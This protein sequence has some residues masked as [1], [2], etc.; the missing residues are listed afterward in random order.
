MSLSSIVGPHWRKPSPVVSE[1]LAMRDL[2]PDHLQ[3]ISLQAVNGWDVRWQLM[4][5]RVL[6][7]VNTLVR[8]GV[9]PITL[10]D[11]QGRPALR[12][13]PG[14]GASSIRLELYHAANAVDA[15]VEIELADTPLNQLEV[16]WVA[17]QDPQ[18]PRF[19]IDVMPDGTPTL[20]GTLRRNL[21]AEEAALRAGLA[22][23]QVRRGLGTLDRMAA[24]LESFMACLNQR[25]YFVQ[26]L[27][28]HT[29]VLFERLGFSYIYG[30]AQMEEI[31]RGF[32]PGGKLRA[33]L[34]GVSPFRTPILAETVRGRAW[35]IHDG[36]L[37]CGWDRVRMVKRL[38]LRAGV[39]TCPDVPW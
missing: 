38:G 27:Y 16:L 28:Y 2:I 17:I 19:N 32:A 7:P 14:E 25:Q 31:G 30:Q 18:A 34:D 39:D 24:R 5:F 6:L 36:L 35:A 22:P 3:P 1:R 29:A 11:A 4:L 33:R 23:G 20:R 37:G 9:D 12:V 21:A 26:P 15:L 13:I 8:F 10:T